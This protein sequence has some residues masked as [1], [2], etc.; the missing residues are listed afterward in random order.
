M[1]ALVRQ[2]AAPPRRGPA[3]RPAWRRTGLSPLHLAI[4]GGL[5]ALG[6]AIRAWIAFTNYGIPYDTDTAYIVARLLAVHP[7]HAYTSLRYPYPGGY[8]PVL[9]LCHWIAQVTGTAFWAVFKVPA[10]LADAGIAAVLAWGLGRLGASPRERLIAV[11]LVTLGPIFVVISGYHGQIDPAGIL[12]ALAGLILWR[13]GGEHRA[14]QAGLLV[15][16]GAAIKTVPLFVVLAMLPT[17]RSRREAA[18]LL[19]CT[20]AVPV[21]SVL[22]FLADNYHYTFK[23]LTFNHGVP[24]FGGLSLLVQPGLLHLWL[25]GQSVILSSSTLFFERL[26]NVIVATGALLA[27]AYAFRR[28]MD[29]IPAAALIWATVYIVN[30]NWAFQYFVW[31]LPFFLLAG[32]RKEATALQLLLALPLAELYFRFGIARLSWLYL[33]LMMLAWAGFVAGAA[34]LIRRERNEIACVG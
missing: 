4:L 14:W 24:G 12:P 21:A 17:V 28:R 15:G 23:S 33:P 30:F 19:G 16:L 26:Q 32:R 8:L 9:L 5:L 20:V 1:S 2:P 25:H 27:G 3:V 7:L 34:A 18:I 22:P 11:A 13:L 10:V 29:P 31:G 6:I